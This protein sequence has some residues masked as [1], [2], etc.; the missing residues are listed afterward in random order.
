LT[1]TVRLVVVGTL[2]GLK[3]RY[4][5]ILRF[6]ET[7]NHRASARAF[8]RKREAA[9]ADTVKP[10]NGNLKHLKTKTHATQRTPLKEAPHDR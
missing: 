10:E 1:N 6:L 2:Y 4:A 9:R 5:H 3:T 8:E 7:K